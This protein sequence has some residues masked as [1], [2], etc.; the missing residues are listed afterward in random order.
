MPRLYFMIFLFWFYIINVFSYHVHHIYYGNFLL[1]LFSSN[2]SV[3]DDIHSIFYCFCFDVI[4][5]LKGH[6]VWTMSLFLCSADRNA[7]SMSVQLSSWQ[8]M[9]SPIIVNTGHLKPL[10][11]TCLVSYHIVSLQVRIFP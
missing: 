8:E 4:A 2:A 1:L 3:S 5:L 6:S 9:C 11:T 10:N 7:K